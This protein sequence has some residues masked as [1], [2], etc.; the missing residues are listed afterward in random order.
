MNIFNIS[1]FVALAFLALSPSARAEEEKPD[2]PWTLYP[3][4]PDANPNC[5]ETIMLLLGFPDHYYKECIELVISVT[6]R[7]KD[8]TVI[9]IS[10]SGGDLPYY[11]RKLYESNFPLH[12]KK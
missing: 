8:G 9:E 7:L 3:S 10:K 4:D 6:L 2:V 11:D 1:L 12:Y 5:Y